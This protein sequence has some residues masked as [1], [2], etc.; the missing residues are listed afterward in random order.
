MTRVRAFANAG[1]HMQ[2]LEQQEMS[3]KPY[4]AQITIAWLYS[5][6]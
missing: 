3:C 5:K 4:C 1:Q 6:I 2:I